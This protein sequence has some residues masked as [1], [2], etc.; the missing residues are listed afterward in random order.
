M[1][2]QPNLNLI[3]G[4]S[5]DCNQD[6]A[7]DFSSSFLEVFLMAISIKIGQVP[8]PFYKN[9]CGDMMVMLVKAQTKFSESQNF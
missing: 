2:S 6:A 7:L 4:P 9:G 3:S 5:A 1:T 8:H